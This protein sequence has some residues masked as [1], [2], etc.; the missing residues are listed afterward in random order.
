M[1]E[2]PDTISGG[3][4]F[5]QA[6]YSVSKKGKLTKLANAD[7]CTYA[8]DQK[9]VHNVDK[10]IPRLAIETIR[11]GNGGWDSISYYKGE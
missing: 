2:A 6:L 9:I 11:W 1:T 3:F 4:N 5:S 8:G 7:A 10:T